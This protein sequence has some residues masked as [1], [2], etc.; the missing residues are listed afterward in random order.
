V[1]SVLPTDKKSKK[2]IKTQPEVSNLQ[3]AIKLDLFRMY[4]ALAKQLMELSTTAN[5]NL[6]NSEKILVDT[7]AL[8]VTLRD[9]I[10]KL[11]KVT[12]NTGEVITTM[13]SYCNAQG[14]P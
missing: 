12:D 11:S 8:K 7:E 9:I 10:G 6:V 13:Q 1:V 3:K 14:Y 5:S 4:D 2:S